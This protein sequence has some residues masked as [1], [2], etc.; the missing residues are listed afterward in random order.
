M[1]IRHRYY[2][3]L[4]AILAMF[5]ANVGVYVL[6]AQ[7]RAMAEREWR[8]ADAVE[9]KISPISQSIAELYRLASWADQLVD[10]VAFV[11]G[12]ER[13]FEEKTDKVKSQIEDLLATAS[14]DQRGEIQS[15]YDNYLEMRQGWI[16]FYH[17]G[18]RDTTG[19]LS[20]I[21]A[22]NVWKR[23]SAEQIP[24]LHFEV[25][26]QAADAWQAAQQAERR[27][28]WAMLGTFSLS[29]IVAVGFS[30][31][32]SRRLSF[33][34]T[35]LTRGAQQ[36]GAMRLDHRIAYHLNDELS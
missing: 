28:N 9:R 29:I 8:R 21:E 4:V 26:S 2:F 25:E 14:P 35:T 17:H 15:F 33:G 24:Q 34:L 20:F 22:E 19:V 10:G 6:S 32:F 18:P 12:E 7:K 11:K 1:S 36:I 27:A 23:V 3:S 31:S 30:Y 5:A 16:S 13:S